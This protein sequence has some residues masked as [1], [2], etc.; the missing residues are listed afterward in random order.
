MLVPSVFTLGEPQGKSDRPLPPYVL[1]NAIDENTGFSMPAISGQFPIASIG[2]AAA[3]VGHLNE[4]TTWTAP[5][6]RNPCW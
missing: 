1:R 5:S 4:F 3:G 6:A 2:E